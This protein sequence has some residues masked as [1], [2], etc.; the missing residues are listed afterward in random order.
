MTTTRLRPT[1][2]IAAVLLLAACG[3]DDPGSAPADGPDS[4]TTA[5]AEDPDAAVTISTADSDLGTI[6]VDGDGMT[7][8]VFDNDSGGESSCYDDC[9]E[10]WPPVT[11]PASADAEA[12]DALMGT[13]TRTD[14]TEQVTYGD[15]P[16]YLYAGD[17][18]AGDVTGQGV[19]E[20]WW[21]VSPDGAAVTSAPDSRIDPE[22]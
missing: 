10:T 20:V 17:G 4:T 1:I 18:D 6:L 14:G 21:V 9:A 16:L 22:Y 7:L 12:D 15:R 19:G 3:D 13:T 8:Y 5:A 2:A 11:G